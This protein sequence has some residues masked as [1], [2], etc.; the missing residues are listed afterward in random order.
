MS[1]PSFFFFKRVSH[2]LLTAF[3]FFLKNSFFIVIQVQFSASPPSPPPPRFYPP[4]A[5][6]YFKT[7]FTFRERGEGRERGRETSMCERYISWVPLSHPQLG[8]WP[9][10]QACALTGNRTGDLS[11]P[12]P[13]LNPLS[14][15][16]RGS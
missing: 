5:T 2:V 12:R 3:N 4:I 1:I 9:T 15:T 11:V 7:L 16:S 14:C 8:A 13:L 10:S 6:S